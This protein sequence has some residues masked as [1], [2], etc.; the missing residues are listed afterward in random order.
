MLKQTKCVHQQ[1]GIVIDLLTSKYLKGG[2]EGITIPFSPT[3]AYHKKQA[4]PTKTKRMLIPHHKHMARMCCSTTMFPSDTQPLVFNV[5]FSSKQVWP[6]ISPATC[7]TYKLRQTVQEQQL[8]RS[9]NII[10]KNQK[11]S[12]PSLPVHKTR[13]QG[14]MLCVVESSTGALCSNYCLKSQLTVNTS[15]KNGHLKYRIKEKSRKQQTTATKKT[16]KK[17]GIES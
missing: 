13:R 2:A 8:H 5:S 9:S 1:A 15:Q 4:S 14:T 16:N 17:K 7:R 11:H 3:L 12:L 10:N 6:L